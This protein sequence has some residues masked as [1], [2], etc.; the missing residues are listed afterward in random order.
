MTKTLSFICALTLSMVMISGC[1]NSGW[2]SADT[3][4]VLGGV[5]GGAAGSQIGSGTGTT[6]ATVVGTL[7][8][9]ALG[10]KLGDNF[11]QRDRRQFGSAL[12]SNPTGNTSTWSDPDSNNN[13]S[14]TPT[15]T[16]NSGS[17]PC[18]EF[19]MNATVD[20]QP[21]KVRGTA[22]RQSDG[23]WKVQS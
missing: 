11:G 8:G 4:T 10:R 19:T 3:G 5:V 7:A 15:R 20:G 6:I 17:Q 16:Y 9:A 22:C 18:R 14:V 2:N 23:T 1:A 13:Y 21:D 12:E